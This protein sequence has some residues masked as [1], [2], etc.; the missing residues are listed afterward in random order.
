MINDQMGEDARISETWC[1]EP[2]DGINDR[3]YRIHIEHLE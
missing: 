3:T 1:I 2:L